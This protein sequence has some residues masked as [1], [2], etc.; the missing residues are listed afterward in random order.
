M[1][2]LS[3]HGAAGDRRPRECAHRCQPG[4]P[5]RAAALAAASTGGPP[6]D[7]PPH[8]HQVGRAD[9]ALDE[10][11][12][13]RSGQGLQVA[14]RGARVQLVQQAPPG[15][16]P[17]AMSW[18]GAG[19]GPPW[20][21]PQAAWSW[22]AVQLFGSAFQPHLPPTTHPVVVLL[23]EAG[24][25]VA[26]DEAGAAGYLKRWQGGAGGA[27]GGRLRRRRQPAAAGRARAASAACPQAAC[28]HQDHPGLVFIWL[29]GLPVAHFCGGVSVARARCV[30]ASF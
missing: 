2:G 4:R 28:T 8:R 20:G 17:A 29:G 25:H 9:V 7:P 30:G 24:H 27:G 14:P 18:P 22:A 1:A 15:C 26:A 6:A 21:P 19:Q 13:R 3:W 16:R 11:E 23:D 10:L 5:R 12:A